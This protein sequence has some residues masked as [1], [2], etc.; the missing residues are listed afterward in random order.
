MLLGFKLLIAAQTGRHENLQTLL[1]QGAPVDFTDPA[2]GATALHYVAAYAARPAFRVLLKSGK[3]DFLMRDRN[4]RLASELAG[5]YGRDLAM[6]RLLLTKEI[7]Q[8]KAEGIDPRSLYKRSARS[9][10]DLRRPSRDLTP[11]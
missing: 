7:R 1:D 10:S 8:A 2:T 3:C 6:E 9:R 4:G 11:R 5:V